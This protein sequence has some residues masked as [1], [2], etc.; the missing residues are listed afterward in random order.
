MAGGGAAVC[1]APLVCLHTESPDVDRR[2]RL[3]GLHAAHGERAN[4]AA[5]GAQGAARG[6]QDAAARAHA[7]LADC[8]HRPRRGRAAAAAALAAPRPLVAAGD[9]R[10]A[11][12]RA[13]HRPARPLR[14]HAPQDTRRA[15]AATLDAPAAARLLADRGERRLLP[16]RAAGARLARVARARR[17]TAHARPRVA[18]LPHVQA[19]GA[20]RAAARDGH[21]GALG[22][23]AAGARGAARERRGGARAGRRRLLH[24]PGDDELPRLPRRVLAPLLRGVHPLVVRALGGAH[25]PALQDAGRDVGGHQLGRL[26]DAAAAALLS[27]PRLERPCG[28][29]PAP[30]SLWD[31]RAIIRFFGL[32]VLLSNKSKE[33]IKRMLPY[34]RRVCLYLNKKNENDFDFGD[35]STLS[36]STT[37]TRAARA[38]LFSARCFRRNGRRGRGNEWRA[39]DGCAG[40]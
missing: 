9:R 38:A 23:A 31:S 21:D 1:A 4:A 36:T 7:R 14:A 2:G 8:P 26:D 40:Q 32:N 5:D 24:L 30:P 13:D 10:G 18:H 27:G 12:A 11:V 15:R 39:D 25:V 20:R 28:A 16:H 33:Y 37:T 35:V 34:P 17:R 22:A 3:A 19:G 6:A 29:R